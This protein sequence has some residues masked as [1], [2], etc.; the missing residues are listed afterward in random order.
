MTPTRSPGERPGWLGDLDKFVGGCW[1]VFTNQKGTRAAGRWEFERSLG[2]KFGNIEWGK[3]VEAHTSYMRQQLGVR[4]GG[5]SWGHEGWVPIPVLSQHHISSQMW[6]GDSKSSP[7]VPL[8][9]KRW[10][11]HP[12]FLMGKKH[13]NEQRCGQSVTGYGIIS[14]RHCGG[15]EYKD[16]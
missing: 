12:A 2:G 1:A 16:K 6:G 14:L 11:Y 3:T 15:T 7:G 10:Q 9:L 8:I 13:M 4:E 5:Q